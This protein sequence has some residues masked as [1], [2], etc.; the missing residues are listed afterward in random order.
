M[1]ELKL[2]LN[3]VG[4]GSKMPGAISEDQFER[5]PI[6]KAKSHISFEILWTFLWR[7][8]WDANDTVARK[9]R[10]KVEVRHVY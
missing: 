4:V 1:M 10:R 3:A 5:I 7:F 8:K 6:I 2:T 9:R